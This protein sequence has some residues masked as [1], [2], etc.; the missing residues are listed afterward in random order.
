[1]AFTPQNAAIYLAA[2]EGAL[3]GLGASGKFLL[4]PVAGDSASAA[5]M[6]DAYAQEID[7]V[8]QAVVG[9][10]PTTLELSVLSLISEGVWETR[11]PI[12]APGAY[13]AGNY[14]GL[15]RG[16]VAL[17]LQ[18]NAQVVSQGV[19][20]APIVATSWLTAMDVD[21]SAQGSQSLGADGPYSIGT[22]PSG[23]ALTW[24]KYNSTGDASPMLVTNGAGLVITPTQASNISNATY[25]A[26]TL[27]IPLSSIVSGYTFSTPVR[28]WINISASNENANY[29]GVY[30]GPL[31]YSATYTNQLTLF[32]FRGFEGGV[33][34]WGAQFEVLDSNVTLTSSSIPF[35]ASR[36]GVLSFPTGFLGGAAQLLAGGA[37][38]VNNAWPATTALTLLAPPAITAS[39]SAA[40]ANAATGQNGP[41]AV[42]LALAALR[43]GSGTNGYSAT[44]KRV[45]VDYLPI[46]T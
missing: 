45:R 4:D 29:D 35:P 32:G 42:N 19:N 24:T 41:S 34:G 14:Y 12:P 13:V 9:A 16:V 3:A 22:D 2:F 28:F 1:M 40:A 27:R 21:F 38:L 20:P 5:Q 36:I 39:S 23:N 44:I 8:W 31:M 37:A 17:I 7:V 26:P 18:G 46:F 6:A 15:C 25:T 10:P 11:S 43:A 33:N 30:F